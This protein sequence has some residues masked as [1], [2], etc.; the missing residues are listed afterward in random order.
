MT[1]PR[2]DWCDDPATVSLPDLRDDDE[3]GRAPRACFDHDVIHGVGRS[4]PV[5]VSS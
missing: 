4:D 3:E 1:V 5:E 2:C